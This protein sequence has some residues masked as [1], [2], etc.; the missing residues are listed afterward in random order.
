VK[1]PH[2]LRILLADDHAIIRRQL[3][4]LLEEQPG[5]QVCAEAA[6]G[7]QA[8]ELALQLQPDVAVLDL[9]MPVMTG[10]EAA[11]LILRASPG[12]QVLIVTMHD[13]EHLPQLVREAGAADCI[14][15]NEAAWRLVPAI[16]AL[17]PR[18]AP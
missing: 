3:R 10:L 6:D 17:V 2:L 12:T 1:A 13:H 11:P 15:K 8:A 4:A 16:E 5:W 7:G 18:K 14:L 9:S